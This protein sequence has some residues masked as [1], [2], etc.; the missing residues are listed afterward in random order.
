MSP[1][2]DFTL[3]LIRLILTGA[4][5]AL[6]I[7]IHILW[8]LLRKLPQKSSLLL[9]YLFLGL[10]CVINIVTEVILYLYRHQPLTI[11]NAPLLDLIKRGDQAVE[12]FF[13]IL[14]LLTMLSKWTF[15][16]AALLQS[17]LVEAKMA[18]KS[19]RNLICGPGMIFI[20]TAS[21][22]LALCYLASKPMMK[23]EFASHIFLFLASFIWLLVLLHL[24]VQCC[25]LPRL[26]DLSGGWMVGHK[27]KVNSLVG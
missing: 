11:R 5:P 26:L 14:A 6:V 10:S 20:N 7:L 8:I 9:V 18:K 27:L 2:H 25:L 12:I 3:F 13:L 17:T 23:S 16:V 21:L 22:A 1:S 4:L 24:L 19:T 15:S